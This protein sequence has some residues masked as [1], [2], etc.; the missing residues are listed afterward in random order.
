ML[1]WLLE[2][3]R[4]A[5]PNAITGFTFARLN[6]IKRLKNFRL[7]AILYSFSILLIISKYSVFDNLKTF[8]YGG[9]RLNIAASCIFIIFSLLPLD[10]IKNKTIIIIIKKFTSYTGGIYYMHYLVGTFYFIHKILNSLN[11]LF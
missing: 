2:D 1:A 11:G 5:F 8:K 9:L 4:K 7:K 10:N 6:I 3:L